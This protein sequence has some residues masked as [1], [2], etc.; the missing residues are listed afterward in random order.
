MLNLIARAV[1]LTCLIFTATAVS[2]PGQLHGYDEVTM[3]TPPLIPCFERIPTSPGVYDEERLRADAAKSNCRMPENGSGVDHTRHVLVGYSVAGDCH[4]KVAVRVF[5]INAERRYRV[6]INNI[7]GGCR[8]GG[9]RK[10]WVMFEKPPD[11]YD[12]DI[13]EINVDRFDSEDGEPLFVFPKPPPVVYTMPLATRLID[14]KDCLPM[15]GETRWVISTAEALGE[16][17]AR[18]PST[19]ERCR[20]VLSEL[21]IDL[22]LETLVGFA[23]QSGHCRPPLDITVEAVREDSSDLAG[24]RYLI[25]LKYEPYAA[26]CAGWT[27]HRVWMTVPQLPYGYGVTLRADPT[28]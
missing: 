8:A 26:A 22:Q 16:A 10:G 25:N 3:L 2:T 1:F 23:F 13:T 4:M 6:V 7:Y 11:G 9:R 24:N 17:L 27:T 15:T 18:H 20:Q 21:D 14:L 12:I 28:E 19:A 5:R